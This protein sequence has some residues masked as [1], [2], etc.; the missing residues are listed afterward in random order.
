MTGELG[1]FRQSLLR[2]RLISGDSVTIDTADVTRIVRHRL[3]LFFFTAVVCLM[4]AL[5]IRGEDRAFVFWQDAIYFG[6]LKAIPVLGIVAAII[7][8]RWRNRT[9]QV[10]TVHLSPLLAAAAALIVASGETVIWV[11]GLTVLDQPMQLAVLW[12][13]LYA[14]CEA[15]T[16]IYCS[17]VLPHILNELHGQRD[18]A[19]PPQTAPIDRAKLRINDVVLD[20]ATVRHVRAEGNYVDIRT[21]SERHYLLA[22]FATVID[23]LAGQDGRQIH[24]SHWVAAR[25]LAG[26]FRDGRDIIVRLEDGTEIAV[27]QSRQKDLLPWLQAVTVRLRG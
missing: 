24:R 14:I 15:E 21:D 23:G 13:L 3:S 19:A 17:F 8:L 25:V 4:L 5:D 9:E 27:A 6:L 1:Q 11:E 22:T 18:P 2:L 7:F 10:V 16:V 26:F 20:P 12:F